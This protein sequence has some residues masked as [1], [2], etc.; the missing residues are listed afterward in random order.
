MSETPPADGPWMDFRGAGPETVGV[1]GTIYDGT[2]ARLAGPGPERASE[3]LDAMP[4][5]L[6]IYDTLRTA[7]FAVLTADDWI[8][9][10]PNTFGTPPDLPMQTV[11]RVATFIQQG[12]NV[13][14]AS[15]DMY[16]VVLAHGA[17]VQTML[18]GMP[19]PRVP[20]NL[21]GTVYDGAGVRVLGDGPKTITVSKLNAYPFK[22]TLGRNEVLVRGGPLGREDRLW[23]LPRTS[24]PPDLPIDLLQDFANLLKQGRRVGL[25]GSD[26]TIGEFIAGALRLAY[27]DPQ[28]SA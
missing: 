21:H 26:R 17:V 4:H 13:G 6:V 9:A 24:M 18:W 3:I 10:L 16:T 1:A 19:R 20:T 11:R 8:W 7:D 27:T 23:L 5:R 2:G 15:R 12:G 14:L 28:G 25:A 22:T